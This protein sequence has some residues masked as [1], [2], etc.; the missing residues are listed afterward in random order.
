MQRPAKETAKPFQEGNGRHQPPGRMH[1]EAQDAANEKYDNQF[2]WI[3]EPSIAD[4]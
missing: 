3:H 2:D 1:D 4:D